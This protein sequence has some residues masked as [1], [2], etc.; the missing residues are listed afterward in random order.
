MRVTLRIKLT[1]IVGAAALGF[2]LLIFT[3]QIIASRVG[4]RLTDIQK[5]YLPG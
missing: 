2:L 5:F 3:G 4:Q 1:A